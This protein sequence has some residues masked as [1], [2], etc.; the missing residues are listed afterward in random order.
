MN[1]SLLK[2]QIVLKGKTLDE[3]AKALKISRS[4]LYRKLNGKSDFTRKEMCRIVDYLG[5]ELDRAIEIF[6]NE[7][8]SQMTQQK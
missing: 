6:F 3:V 7:K 8:V 4:A 1:T 5:I 2:A